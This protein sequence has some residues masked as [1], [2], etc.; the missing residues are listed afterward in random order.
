MNR[1]AFLGSVGAAIPLGVAGRLAVSDG[2]PGLDVRVWFSER[3]ARYDS[4]SDRVRGYLGRALRDAVDDVELTIADAPVAL[5]AEGGTSV[6]KVHWPRRVLEGATGFG[7]VRPI[8][9]V[10]LLVTDGDPTSQPAGYAHRRVAAAAGAAQIAAMPPASETPWIVPY[11][12]RAAATQ[13]LLHECG[14]AMGLGHDDGNALVVGNDV[15]ASPM[16]SS[17]LWKPREVR[18][19]HLDGDVNACGS[20]LPDAGAAPGRRL[21]LRFSSCASESL[22]GGRLSL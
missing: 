6:F 17:Y 14:H 3:A 5:P 11:S 12:V 19:K 15:I 1:R 22:D 21:E 20:S 8:G 16:V 18:E 2:D 9:D 10:N 7:D 13:L 4:L